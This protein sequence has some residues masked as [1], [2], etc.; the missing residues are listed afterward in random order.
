LSPLPSGR[1]AERDRL[2]RILS[3]HCRADDTAVRYLEGVLV[4]QR[5]LED[6]LGSVRMV[7]VVQAEMELVAHLGAQARGRRRTDLATLLAEYHEFAGRMADYNGEHRA[8]LYHAGRALDA[9]R[10]LDRADLVAAAFGLR[11]HLAWGTG[12]AA[13]TIAFAEAGQRDAHALSPGVAGF[14]TQMLG[15]GHAQQGDRSAAERLIDRSDDLTARAAAHPE[16]EPWW[17]Y[18]QTPGRARLQRGLAYLELG[19]PG[20]ARTVI[21]EARPTL[22]GPCRRDRGRFAASL[23]LACALAGDVETAVV[24]GK[25]AVEIVAGTGPVHAVDDL[26]RL[27]GIVGGQGTHDQVLEELDEA[28]GALAGAS[29]R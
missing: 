15:R 23:A 17:T 4:H 10:E 12:D 25:E 14:L 16:D 26:R 29:V 11:S 20:Q 5:R 7:P 6:T 9:A 19:L 3:G 28:F 2:A 27:R 21:D 13:G 24:A 18:L 8:A 1:E 22:P